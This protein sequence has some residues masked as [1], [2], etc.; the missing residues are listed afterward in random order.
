MVVN[1]K[2]LFEYLRALIDANAKPSLIKH[3]LSKQVSETKR[4]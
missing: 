3:L 1:C 2:Y 4:K